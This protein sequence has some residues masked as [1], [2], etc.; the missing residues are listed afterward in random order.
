[1]RSSILT[2]QNWKRIP[3]LLGSLV[4]SIDVFAQVSPQ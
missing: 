3:V 1:M 4:V 2:E